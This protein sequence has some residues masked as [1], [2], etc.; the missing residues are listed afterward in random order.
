[1]SNRKLLEFYRVAVSDEFYSLSITDSQTGKTLHVE[2][3][4]G[5]T[6]CIALPYGSVILLYC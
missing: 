2:D 4:K 6:I 3:L 1:M 5:T